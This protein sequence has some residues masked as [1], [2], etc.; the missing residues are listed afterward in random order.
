MYMV[1]EITDHLESFFQI[2]IHTGDIRSNDQAGKEEHGTAVFPCPVASAG[3]KLF[4]ER[5]SVAG[6]VQR[7][8]RLWKCG[9]ILCSWQF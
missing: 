5:V 6:S 4:V 9:E 8:L 7:T 3:L 2:E 1:E